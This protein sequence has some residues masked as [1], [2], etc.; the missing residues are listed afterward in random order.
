MS[1]EPFEASFRLQQIGT[2][3]L[4]SCDTAKCVNP[5]GA[6]AGYRRWDFEV[7]VTTEHPPFHVQQSS[8][9]ATWGACGDVQTLG[10]GVLYSPYGSWVV[11][12]D[13][14]SSSA[15]TQAAMASLS[16][17]VFTF[18]IAENEMDE[19]ACDP[20]YGFTGKEQVVNAPKWAWSEALDSAAPV[21]QCPTLIEQ[22][23]SNDPLPPSP[24]PP[25][26]P[27]SPTP[28]SASG[29]AVGGGV[30]AAVLLAAAAAA[31][32]WRKRR[33]SGAFAHGGAKPVGSNATQQGV[34][35]SSVQNPAL[36]RTTSGEVV[37]DRPSSK[38]MHE[39]TTLHEGVLSKKGTGAFAKWQPRRF[40]LASHYLAYSDKSHEMTRTIDLD[41]VASCTAIGKD[42]LL[43]V[44]KGDAADAGAGTQTLRA[45]DAQSAAQWGAQ[46]NA[47][48][49]AS[50]S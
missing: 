48:M 50:R 39:A 18:Q 24:S 41:G 32:V 26:S 40:K 1:P 20:C 16:K 4:Y 27:S 14:W 22:I 38:S 21:L 44:V 13:S 17:V 34:E 9:P 43:V 31:L 47:A 49:Q 23:A 8:D 25:P 46:I 11:A 29:A 12:L 3:S 15:A 19:S 5:T 33:T 7:G 45:A 35:L 28:A 6:A 2:T 42:I 36:E 30:S 37:K 10:A